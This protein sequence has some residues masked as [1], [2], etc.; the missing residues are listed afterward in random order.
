MYYYF[1]YKN[2]IKAFL[3]VCNDEGLVGL[4]IEQQKYYREHLQHQPLIYEP[5]HPLLQQVNHWLD[6]YFAGKNPCF[7]ENLFKPIGSQFQKQVWNALLKIPYGQTQSYQQFTLTLNLNA[8]YTRAVANAI[9]HNPI[10]IM[11]PCHRV[12][13]KHGQLVGYSGGIEI[14][15]M[16][17]DIE[18]KFKPLS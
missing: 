1:I 2:W 9:K 18:S 6:D 16:L 14:K 3:V 7:N 11:I 12:I 4:W 13:G 17:L 10:S 15:K 8:T 5:K